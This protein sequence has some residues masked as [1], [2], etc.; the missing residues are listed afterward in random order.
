MKSQG[1]DAKTIEQESKRFLG[2]MG[3][4]SEVNGSGFCPA[5]KDS[6]TGD[7]HPSRF[8]DGTLATLHV[9]DGLPNH[10]VLERNNNG[11]VTKT[12]DWLIT[13]FIKDNQFYTRMEVSNMIQQ[14]NT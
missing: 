7:V 1:L 13:G 4:S 9:L 3:T 14:G 2:R 6:N 10:L 12:V 8:A 11:H 5:F